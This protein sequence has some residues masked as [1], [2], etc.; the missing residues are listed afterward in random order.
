MK[1]LLSIQLDNYHITASFEVILNLPE[2]RFVKN[3]FYNWYFPGNVI[4]LGY[5][6]QYDLV[7]D[8]FIG[9]NG[10]WNVKVIACDMFGDPLNNVLSRTH[11]TPPIE[12]DEVVFNVNKLR[13]F[14]NNHPYI[15]S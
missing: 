1:K 3:L 10:L 5:W 13:E 11:Y 4:W 2:M 6:K 15:F 9:D 7:L 8:F 14:K 12:S